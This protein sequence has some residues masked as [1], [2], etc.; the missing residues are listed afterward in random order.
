MYLSVPVTGMDGIT[1]DWC[2]PLPYTPDQA[3]ELGLHK[4]VICTESTMLASGDRMSRDNIMT[5]SSALRSLCPLG[6]ARLD[7]EHA[8]PNLAKSYESEFGA[9]ITKYPHGFVIDCKGVDSPQGARS[10]AIIVVENMALR[11]AILH[12]RVKGLSVTDAPRR[13]VCPTVGG[14]PCVYESSSYV[15]VT[16]ALKLEPDAPNTWIKPVGPED[17]GTIITGRAA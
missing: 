8:G 15:A 3:R 4:A 12:G 5:G 13:R 7:V 10:E 9:E 16:C 14:G 1:F 11:N 2:T 17:R 6:M